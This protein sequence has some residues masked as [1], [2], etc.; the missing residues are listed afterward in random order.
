VPKDGKLSGDPSGVPRAPRA[1]L[2]CAVGAVACSILA[3]VAAPALADAEV[4]ARV[5][6]PDAVAIDSV[7]D[8]FVHR[9]GPLDRS[10][11]TRFSPDGFVTA[12]VLLDGSGSAEFAQSRLAVDPGS[13]D[14][15]LLSQLG[16]IIRFRPDTLDASEVVDLSLADPSVVASVFD[17]GARTFVRLT[18]VSPVYGAIT[19]RRRDARTLEMFVTGADAGLAAYPFIVRVRVD[20]V[21]S[22]VEVRVIVTIQSPGLGPRLEP[23]RGIGV[24]PSG[25]VVTALPFPAV[26]GTAPFAAGASGDALLSFGAGFPEDPAAAAPSFVPLGRDGGPLDVDARGIAV[27]AA[28]DFYVATGAAGT[29]PCGPGD[30]GQVLLVSARLA[31]IGCLSLGG[32]VGATEDVAVAPSG[33]V[34]AVVPSPGVLVDVPSPAGSALGV[35]SVVA[36]TVPVSQQGGGGCAPLAGGS[37]AGAMIALPTLAALGAR[38][39]TRRPTPRG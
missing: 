17:V 26:P 23:R 36:A 31:A 10:V 16:R 32:S 18:L 11:L 9:Q 20:L 29:A 19:A 33:E 38:R 2:R 24:G 22:A 25:T 15:L 8:V 12:E 7:G 39:R 34:V 1:R 28:G 27:D 5:E 30:A 35:A 37:R 6:A 14:V 3:S 21:T 4:F 13:G